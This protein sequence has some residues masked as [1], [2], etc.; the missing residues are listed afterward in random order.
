MC[1]SQGVGTRE[2]GRLRRWRR[3]A[4]RCRRHLSFL[5][6]DRFTLVYNGTVLCLKSLARPNV[7]GALPSSF[8]ACHLGPRKNDEVAKFSANKKSNMIMFVAAL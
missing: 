1:A 4:V 5:I 2:Q 3:Y 8:D 7:N 6:S